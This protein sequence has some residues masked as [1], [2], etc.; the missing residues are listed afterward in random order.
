MFNSVNV[1]RNRALFVGDNIDPL[2]LMPSSSA[3]LI[4]LDPPGN[5]GRT[6][7]TS[8]RAKA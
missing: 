1:F 4:Y 5:T 3:D 7:S 2:R 8:S 6:Y